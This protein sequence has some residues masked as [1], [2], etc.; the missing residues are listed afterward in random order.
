MSKKSTN[1]KAHA[2]VNKKDK[3]YAIHGFVADEIKRH[4]EYCK[5]FENKIICSPFDSRKGGAFYDA[6]FQ[7]RKRLNFDKYI[8][9]SFEEDG[10][11][12]TQFII[13]RNEDGTFS[14]RTEKLLGDGDYRSDEVIDIMKNSNLI[15]ANPCGT[16]M[17]DFL[18][19]IINKLQKEYLVLGSIDAITYKGC[20]VEKLEAQQIKGGYSTNKAMP[21]IIKDDNLDDGYF[22]SAMGVDSQ[23]KY[24]RPYTRWWLTNLPM[25]K[26]KI[27]DYFYENGVKNNRYRKMKFYNAIECQEVMYIPCDYYEPIAVPISFLSGIDYDKWEILNANDYRVD[28]SVPIKPHGIIKDAEGEVDRGTKRS[29]KKNKNGKYVTYPRIMIRR[30]SN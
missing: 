18:P 17:K 27:H 8:G 29:P 11:P 30:R 7:F 10:S 26:K 21:F 3:M 14:E 12:A 22:F 28:D 6:F 16:M 24:S 19:L 5:P 4:H 15:V 9:L 2:R 1:K 20:G 25:P 13:E 23:V